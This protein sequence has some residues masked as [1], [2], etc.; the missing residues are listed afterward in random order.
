MREL[1]IEVTVTTH[2]NVTYKCIFFNFIFGCFQFIK[3]IVFRE[4][5]YT[6]I[7]LKIF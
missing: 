4:I 1:D 5:F 2:N 6:N 3:I 7:P